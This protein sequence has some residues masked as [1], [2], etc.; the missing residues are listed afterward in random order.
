MQFFEQVCD[1]RTVLSDKVEPD[2]QR[3]TD[4]VYAPC[5]IEAK[6]QLGY[7][8][9]PTQAR[10]LGEFYDRHEHVTNPTTA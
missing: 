4:D 9:T 10:L 8:L 6:R 5:W 2:A 1:G 3:V 7:A